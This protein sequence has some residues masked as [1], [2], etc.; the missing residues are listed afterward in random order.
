[1][2][3]SSSDAAARGNLLIALIPRAT[4]QEYAGHLLFGGTFPHARIFQVFVRQQFRN[5]GVARELIEYLV[6]LLERYGYLSAA[7]TV[8]DDLVANGF[9]EKLGFLVA[10]QKPGGVSRKRLLNVRIKQLN[11]PNLFQPQFPSTVSDLGLVERLGTHTAVYAIDLNVF[12]DVVKRRPRSEYA[13]DVIGAAFNRLIQIVV[14]Q[15][16]QRASAHHQT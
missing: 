14:A 2:H 10:R 12:W 8:A 6:K 5:R 11:S 4:S 9:W 16:H 7:A 15:I 1:M 3:P 13:A